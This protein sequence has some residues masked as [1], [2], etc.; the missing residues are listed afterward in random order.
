M[1]ANQLAAKMLEWARKRE[2]LDAIEAEIAAVVLAIGQSK[3]TGNVVAKYSA[4]S[5][6]FD[7]E[8]PARAAVSD[9]PAIL[10]K[11]TKTEPVT[12][13]AA[14]CKELGVDPI[15]TGKKPASVKISLAKGGE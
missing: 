3:K 14:V 6:S 12:D 5:R 13:W 1:N 7:Y 9:K 8:T 10:A 4:G 2:E 15:V 11:H